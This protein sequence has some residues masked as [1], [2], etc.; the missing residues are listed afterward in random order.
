VTYGI[1]T[2][3]TLFSQNVLI[4]NIINTTFIELK[5]AVDKHAHFNRPLVSDVDT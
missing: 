2:I 3:N 1:V 4:Y 5:L